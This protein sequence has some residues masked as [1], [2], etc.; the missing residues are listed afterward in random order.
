MRKILTYILFRIVLVVVTL[1]AVI[2]HPHSEELTIEKHIE[3]HKD[4]NSFIG[5]IRLVFH[6]NDDENLDNLIFAE[7]ENDNKFDSKCKYPIDSIF[8][9]TQSIIEKRETKIIA[10]WNTNNFNRLL[11]VKLNRLRGP[12]ELA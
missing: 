4:S 1:H 11:F 7:F 6:E 5:I 8:N 9:S 3:L 2:S 10:K 12:P